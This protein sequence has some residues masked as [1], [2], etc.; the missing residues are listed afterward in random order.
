MILKLCVVTE[1]EHGD[2]NS[3]IIAVHLTCRILR[4]IFKLKWLLGNRDSDTVP[5]YSHG[6]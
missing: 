5:L 3:Q 1:L 4:R 6:M 2:Q